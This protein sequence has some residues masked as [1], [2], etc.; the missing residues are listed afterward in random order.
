M[1]HTSIK[2][3]KKAQN[4]VNESAIIGTNATVIDNI[5]GEYNI[6]VI[7][8]LENGKFKA[9]ITKV[10]SGNL[11]IGDIVTISN[12]ENTGIKSV[13]GKIINESLND[14]AVGDLVTFPDN[15]KQIELSGKTGKIEKID[16][17]FAYFKFDENTPEVPVNIYDLES[18]YEKL[19]KV[20]EEDADINN[21]GEVNDQDAYLK[22]KRGT[23]S[24]K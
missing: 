17:E 7:E 21:D 14:V 3:W 22:N 24:K 15:F 18:L 6:E 13:F 11:N 12:R 20:G 8:V 16:G 4:K 10:I 19:D 1:I 23:I 5:D 9:K 2:A